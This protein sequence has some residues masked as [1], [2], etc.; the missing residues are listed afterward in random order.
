MHQ[1]LHKI[2]FITALEISLDILFS[3]DSLLTGYMGI[4]SISAW[5]YVLCKFI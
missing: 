4:T 3:L 1:E 5:Y 2:D